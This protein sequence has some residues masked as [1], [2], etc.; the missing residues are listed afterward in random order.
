[1]LAEPAEVDFESMSPPELIA[2][3]VKVHHAYVETT[4]PVLRAYLS[5]LSSVHGERH[6]EL[7]QIRYLFDE[8]AGALTAHMKKE[9][10]ILFPFINRMFRSTEPVPEPHFGHI[11]NPISMMEHEHAMEGKRFAQIAALSE[12]YTPP[13][14]GCQT[15]RVAFAVLDEF[16]KDLHKHIHLEN[17]I[18][19]PKARRAYMGLGTA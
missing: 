8:T 2:H 15:Y 5:K 12:D 4:I 16:E 18:L 1:M 17:N 11:D 3:I 9:E 7:H 6:P 19:S 10:F 14:D 13:P